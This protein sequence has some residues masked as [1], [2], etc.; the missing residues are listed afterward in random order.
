MAQ[1]WW[2]LA[3]TAC[4]GGSFALWFSLNDWERARYFGLIAGIPVTVFAVV[5]F[6]KWQQETKL[7][8]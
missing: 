6:W 1:H 4:I 5:G 7:K 3:L 8:I 2:P